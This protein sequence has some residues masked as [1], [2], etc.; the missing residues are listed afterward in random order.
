MLNHSGVSGNSALFGGGIQNTG[1]TVV[2]ND[3]TI[4]DNTATLDGGGLD[5]YPAG[6]VIVRG[7][8]PRRD[9]DRL[10]VRE[11][12][13]GPRPRAGT[14]RKSVDPA[15]DSARVDSFTLRRWLA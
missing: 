13:L 12:A 14:A 1:G 6:A 3:S 7:A 2:L 11:C 10:T 4:T 8:S 15:S 9:P 5:T